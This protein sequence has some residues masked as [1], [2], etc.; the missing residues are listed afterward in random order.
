MPKGDKI[1]PLEELAAELAVLRARNNQQK[2]VQCHG[3]FD[4]LH[5][6][7][8]RHFQ[9]AKE[10]GDV[11][12]VT[13]TSD[14]Y[15][16]KG[17]HRPAF[18]DLLRAEAIAALDCVDFVAINRAPSAVEAIKLIRPDVFAKGPDYKDSEADVTGN[19][20]EEEA[21]VKSLGGK[22]LFTDG[23]LFSS[24]ALINRYLPMFPSEVTAYLNRFSNRYS[25]A[26][27]TQYIRGV[28]KLKTLVVGEAIIDEYQYC[29]QMGKA[30]KEPILSVRYLST[31]WFAG[32]T[33]AVA[34][35][36]AN[37]CENVGLLTLLGKGSTHENFI[38]QKLNSK[39]EGLFLFNPAA[40]TIVKR[41]F[42]ES[43]L[44][45]KLFEVYEM[46]DEPLGEAQN[47]ALC[48]KLDEVIA[49]YDVVIVVDYGHGMLTKEAIDVLCRK[50]R[51]LS[52]STQANSGN[53]GL[54]TIS[55]YPRADYVCLAQHEIQLEER[56]SR[57]SLNDM[58]LS[59]SRKL[60]CGRI[61][62][63]CGRD[64][65]ASYSEEEGFSHAPGFTSHVL[66]RIGAGDAVLSVTAPCVAL[67]MPMEVVGFVGNV[68]GAEAVAIVANQRSI[69]PVTLFKHIES[70]LK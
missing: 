14:Q 61:L 34:N 18:T 17:P 58:I 16:N 41:R 49:D 11:L 67:G 62:V 15:V 60:N 6:G 56:T 22:T 4:L 8:I 27:V 35:H 45:Q 66:D 31:E 21:A 40:P 38:R 42:V 50:S 68:V 20:L 52:V 1:Q 30:A 24:S 32:G 59:V 46:N 37:F 51:F 69:E 9:Q 53:K 5:V 7:H 57:G 65:N 33:I 55:R 39:V 3:V 44:F 29:E 10:S 70:L 63:T 47:Q 54:N 23:I 43:Y 36:V 12:V 48:A 25:S 28:R 64:G 2:I 19:I 26:D 13:V